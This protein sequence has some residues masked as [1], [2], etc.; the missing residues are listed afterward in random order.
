LNIGEHVKIVFFKDIYTMSL[1]LFAADYNEEPNKEG[2]IN[3]KRRLFN[4]KIGMAN[5]TGGKKP[6][7]KALSTLNAIHSNLD[8]V[9]SEETG[10]MNF[11]PIDP[12]ESAGTEKTRTRSSG[13]FRD[14]ESEGFEALFTES[15][16]EGGVSGEG[17]SGGDGGDGGD[18]GSGGLGGDGVSDGG[19][20]S[21]YHNQFVPPSHLNTPTQVNNIRP[22]TRGPGPDDLDQ[23]LNYLI[24]LIEQQRGEKTEHVTEEILLY[25]LVGVFVIYVVD[26]FVTIGKYRR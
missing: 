4:R 24:E 3:Q 15:P 1:A 14:T 26:S 25:G 5:R 13:E 2:T 7:S 18:G 19:Y 16:N 23:K 8:E 11:K 10:L 20:S 21:Q 22:V 6:S 9:E 17:G 12:P